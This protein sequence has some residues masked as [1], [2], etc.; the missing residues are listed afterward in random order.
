MFEPVPQTTKSGNFIRY[1][2]ITNLSDLF[3]ISVQKKQIHSD[4]F[5]LGS[6]W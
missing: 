6:Q 1:S 5:L 3:L 2:T 4:R